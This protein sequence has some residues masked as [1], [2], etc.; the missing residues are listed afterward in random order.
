MVSRSG[1]TCRSDTGTCASRG[2]H[3]AARTRVTGRAARLCHVAASAQIHDTSIIVAA[4]AHQ[5]SA[6]ITSGRAIRTFVIARH[7]LPGG[8]SQTFSRGGVAVAA[9]FGMV[10][11]Q[12]DK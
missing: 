10:L 8:W 4:G 3:V 12:E 11:A 6:Q 1:E 9:A 5:P 7:Y 2:R